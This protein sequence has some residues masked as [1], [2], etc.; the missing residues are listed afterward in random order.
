[1]KIGIVSDT[2][3][4]KEYLQ[5]V[6]EWMANR[7]KIAALYHL[8]D[9]YDDV[10]DLGDFFLELV[11]VPGTYDIRYKN[12]TLPAKT[13]ET[14]LGLNILLIHSIEKDL[15]EDDI[16]RSDIILHGHTHHEELRLDDGRL[17]MNPGHLKGPLDKNLPPTFGMIT[18]LDNEVT[19]AIYNMNF[20]TVQTLELI[21]SESGLYRVS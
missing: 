6:V 2:H 19:A 9:E 4:N 14:I 1:M 16:S 13:T 12:G 8:G 7:Q 10:V 21:R 15:T 5:T 11:Q 3:R 18:I 17:Y 20:K